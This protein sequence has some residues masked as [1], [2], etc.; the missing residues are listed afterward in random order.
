MANLTLSIDDALLRA[1]R[2]RAVAEGTSVNE[3]C[4]RAIE[5]YA[6]PDAPDERLRRFDAFMAKI[7]RAGRKSIPAPWKNRE[8]MYEILMAERGQPEQPPQ[9]QAAKKPSG[10]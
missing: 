3:I 10:K 7:E 8:E 4:R 9:A 2:V 1:A 6:K 5:A